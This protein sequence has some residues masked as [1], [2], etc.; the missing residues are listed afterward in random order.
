M[1]TAAL[2]GSDSYQPRYNA[3]VNATGCSDAV[4]SLQCLRSLPFN[5][6]NAAINSSTASSWFPVVDGDF[7]RRYPSLQL[8]AGEFLK[9]PIIDG[10][11]SD[12]GIS[13]GP[14]GYNTSAQFV[15]GLECKQTEIP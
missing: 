14:R 6:L 12:E 7:I 3:I 4:D 15:A 11:N 8:A 9:V 1:I 10:A 5:S 2:R 13:F